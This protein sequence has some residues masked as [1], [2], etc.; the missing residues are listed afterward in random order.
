MRKCWLQ[1]FSPF[2]TMFSNCLLLRVVKSRDCVVKG[3]PI[4]SPNFLLY[5]IQCICR[6]QIHSLPSDK[7]LV[8]T[9]LKAFAD[10][11]SNIAKTRISVFDTVE[12]IVEKGENTR[13]QHFLFFPQCF[14][15]SSYTGL[16]K[17]MIV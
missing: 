13:Y 2:P 3:K 10:D 14:Q 9:K 17:V 7:T 1:A 4:K 12:N 6:R 16:L 5:Q 15:K 8:F 11:K